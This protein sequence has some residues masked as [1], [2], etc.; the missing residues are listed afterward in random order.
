MTF[1]EAI[2]HFRNNT[3]ISGTA[4][5]LN[6]VEDTLKELREEYVPTVEMTKTQYAFITS[7]YE[8]IVDAVANLSVDNI[9]KENFHQNFW[10]PLTQREVVIAWLHPETIKVVDV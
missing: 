3:D 4:V 1:D 8:N 7:E 2:E 5:F 9:L 6:D 10:K